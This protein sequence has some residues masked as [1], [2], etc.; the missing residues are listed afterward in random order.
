MAERRALL[1]VAVVGAGPSGVEMVATLADLLPE[2]YEKLGGNSRK[3]RIVLVNH[4]DEILA[5]D[6][7]AHLQETAL[8]ALKSRAVPVEVVRCGSGS[9]QRR[10]ANLQC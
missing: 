6:V 9:C 10:R 8:Q 5:G 4:G 7:N 2:W 1:T 3:L